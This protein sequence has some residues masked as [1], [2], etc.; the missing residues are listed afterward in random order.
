MSIGQFT[1]KAKIKC[2]TCEHFKLH[3]G[4]AVGDCVVDP[5][6][7]YLFGLITRFPTMEEHNRCG[8]HSLLS[9]QL[10]FNPDKHGNSHAGFNRPPS[11]DEVAVMLKRQEARRFQLEAEQGISSGI[12]EITLET[13][14]ADGKGGFLGN[15]AAVKITGEP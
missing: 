2:A 13:I 4:S 10:A 7:V 5:P 1:D 15:S 8:R 12:P 6:K 9:N 11:L 14:K 3:D